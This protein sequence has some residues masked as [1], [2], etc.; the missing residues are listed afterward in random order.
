MLEQGLQL[1]QPLSEQYTVGSKTWIYGYGDP[2]T[3]IKRG[4]ID[5]SIVRD[6]ISIPEKL[7]ETLKERYRSFDSYMR[8]IS[9]CITRNLAAKSEVS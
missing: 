2:S 7:A 6:P 4:Y 3:N 8:G 9:T 1:R 5:R